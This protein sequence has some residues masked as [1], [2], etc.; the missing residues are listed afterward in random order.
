MIS[1]VAMYRGETLA[2]SQLVAVS[3]AP[4]VVQRVAE[5]LLA[6][7]SP[8]PDPICAAVI[9]GKRRALELISDE[10]ATVNPRE[11]R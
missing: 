10:S 2:D 11:D 9:T 4:R 7:Q 8:D 3:N 6:N 5:D 1:Y